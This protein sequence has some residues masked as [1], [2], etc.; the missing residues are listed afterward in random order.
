MKIKVDSSVRSQ[1]ERGRD[2]S[3]LAG[4][5]EPAIDGAIRSALSWYE[6]PLR[7]AGGDCLQALTRTYLVGRPCPLLPTK[8]AFAEVERL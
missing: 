5:P 3:R 1:L 6:M 2:L 4:V 7:I 8:P